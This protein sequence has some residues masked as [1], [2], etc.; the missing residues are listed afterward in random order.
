VDSYIAGF[1]P[2]TRTSLEEVRRAIAQAAPDATECISY[3]MP[4]FKQGRVLVR[5]GGRISDAAAVER[6]LA[7]VSRSVP[8]DDGQ[9]EVI[10]A[11]ARIERYPKGTVLLEQG[12]VAHRTW[13]VIRGC[14][15]VF[16]TTGSEERT[17][18]LLTEF[19]PA[20]PPTYGTDV[21]SPVSFEC[22]EDLVASTGTPDDEAATY[23]AHPSFQSVCRIMGQVLMARMQ[24]THIDV[25]TRS[26]RERYLDLVERRPDLLQR[27]PQ[28][29][30]ANWLGIQPET[31]S[32]IRRRLAR[33]PPA[34]S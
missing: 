17:L 33:T 28:Y 2:A 19:Q 10:R 11:S 27:V 23:A 21:P 26:P 22:L 34:L 32:R 4:A 30:I 24:A 31:L 1:P 14:V 7:F 13:L 18:D 20:A 6:I 29:H 3:G 15:R 25:L 5:K 9:R 12:T 16:A 8:L